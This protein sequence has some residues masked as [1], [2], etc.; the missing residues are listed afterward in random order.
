[1]DLRMPGMA[2]LAAITQIRARWPHIAIVILT[3]FDE[4]DLMLRSLRAGA[5]GFLLKDTNRESL[6]QAIRAAARGELL[7]QPEILARILART[8]DGQPI[9]AGAPPGELTVREREVLQA[10]AAGERSKEIASRLGISIRTVGSY[11]TSIYTK[12]N[13]DSRASAVAAGIE[14]GLL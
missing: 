4:D 13:V 2:G 8:S 9:A 11:I 3:T 5:C 12:L 7:L 10:I 6:F 14:R 1:M